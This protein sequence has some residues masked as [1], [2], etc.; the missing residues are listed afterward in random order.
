[1]RMHTHPAE[2]R[3]PKRAAA[4]V[5]RSIGGEPRYLFISSSSSDDRLVLPAGNVERGESNVEAAG[6][7]TR[8]ESGV[9]VVVGPSLGTF[10]H[11]KSSGRRRLTEAFLARPVGT[12]RSDEMRRKVW[13]SAAQMCGETSGVPEPIRRI[14]LRAHAAVEATTAAA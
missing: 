1:M 9:A 6:R 5:Y 10:W 2:A 7:E 13:L 11:V 4:I 12:C 3:R 8:E 14:V